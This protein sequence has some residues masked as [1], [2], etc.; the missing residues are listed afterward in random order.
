MY[1]IYVFENIIECNKNKIKKKMQK[2]KILSCMK[3]QS[4]VY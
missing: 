4:S 2:I 3:N 1:K